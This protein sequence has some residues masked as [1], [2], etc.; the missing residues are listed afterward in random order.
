[1]AHAV[2]GAAQEQGASRPAGEGIEG[3][4]AAIPAS[5]AAFRPYDGVM[6]AEIVPEVVEQA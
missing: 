1:M 6:T 2:A 5:R 3:A 4:A